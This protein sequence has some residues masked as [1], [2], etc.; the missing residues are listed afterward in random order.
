MRIFTSDNPGRTTTIAVIIIIIT[1]TI[2]LAA[3]VNSQVSGIFPTQLTPVSALTKDNQVVATARLTRVFDGRPIGSQPIRPYLLMPS[4]SIPLGVTYTDSNGYARITFSRSM[5]PQG[6]Q[7]NFVAWRY[8][9]NGIYSAPLPI[10]LVTY[11]TR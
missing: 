1:I 6:Q 3:V 7:F 5:L 8:D 9:G 11:G 2:S 10:S 4:S